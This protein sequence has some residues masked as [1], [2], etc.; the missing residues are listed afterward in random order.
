[1]LPVTAGRGRSRGRKSSAGAAGAQ[2]VALEEAT[3]RATACGRGVTRT[4]PLR[5]VGA[6]LGSRLPAPDRRPGAQDELERNGKPFVLP[7][8]AE[9]GRHAGVRIAQA[10]PARRPAQ[11]KRPRTK[12]PACGRGV[13][14]TTLLR[15]VG[16]KAPRKKAN[17]HVEAAAETWLGVVF[18]ILRRSEPP[19]CSWWR[20][21][22]LAG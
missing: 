2:A 18:F 14:R 4:T 9:R 22:R 21:K 20:G 11:W 6:K 1:M 3:N 5:A 15:A 8:K 16:A 17:G 19:S 7:M 10:Q 13:A 12:A